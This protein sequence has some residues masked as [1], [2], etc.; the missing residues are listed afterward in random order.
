MDVIVSSA[1][2]NSI[3]IVI[4]LLHFNSRLGLLLATARYFRIELGLK[5]F[6]LNALL[7]SNL[8]D[9]FVILQHFLPLDPTM[10]GLHPNRYYCPLA[11]LLDPTRTKIVSI[12]D[13]TDP[14]VTHLFENFWRTHRWVEGSII[15]DN[16]RDQDAA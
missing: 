4:Y 12:I 14:V 2:G 5:C 6:N 13:I 11:T 9:V 1:V 8:D 7:V 10:S 3:V 16:Q 15:Y